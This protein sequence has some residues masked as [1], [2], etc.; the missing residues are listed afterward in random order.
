MPN[1]CVN[2]LSVVGPAEQVSAFIRLSETPKPATGDPEGSINYSERLEKVVFDFHGAVPLPVEYSKVP[3][4]NHPNA[5]GYDMERETWGVKWGAYDID[6]AWDREGSESE[7]ASI[8]FTTA[9]SPPA[10]WM[11]KASINFPELTF[12]LSFA[13]ESPSR[14]RYVVRGGEIIEERDDPYTDWY[15]SYDD[16]MS[17]EEE[18]ALYEENHE[19]E[20]ELVNTH[21]DWV[22]QEWF[23]EVSS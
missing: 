12:Y 4:S 10:I 16:D 11:V 7:I 6:E 22:A 17:E 1:H 18:E 23:N 8:G 15:K 19:A 13:E 14:G 3:Y 21:N 9:W 5:G 2:R 20:M